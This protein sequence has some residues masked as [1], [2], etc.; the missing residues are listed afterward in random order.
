MPAAYGYI[1]R[2]K[3]ADGDHFDVFLGPNPTSGKAFVI[4]QNTPDGKFDELKAVLGA[5]DAAEAR[6]LYLRSFAGDH[7]AKIFGGMREMSLPDFKAFLQ[8]PNATARPLPNAGGPSAVLPK[9][10]ATPTDV[11][12]AI[13][14]AGG[15]RDDG[16]TAGRGDLRAMGA[17]GR[18][19]LINNRSGMPLDTMREHLAQLG[20]FDHLYGSPAEASGRRAW[21]T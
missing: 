1:R 21:R 2:T 16:K 12:R 4:S 3:G 9:P 6:D 19:G 5:K 13:Q 10:K 17:Y 14:A 7:G 18:P 20:Y 8:T 15:I 11:I